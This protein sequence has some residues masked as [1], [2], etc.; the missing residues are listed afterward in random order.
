MAL[1]QP[2]T[3]SQIKILEA[4]LN[5]HHTASSHLQSQIRKTES[6]L[7]HF[8]EE[9]QRVGEE[10]QLLESQLTRVKVQCSI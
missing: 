2:R 9:S 10:N 8:S 6:D 4:D 1:L 3:S 5:K 7:K